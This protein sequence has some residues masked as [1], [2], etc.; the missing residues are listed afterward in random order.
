MLRTRARLKAP[1]LGI[2]GPWA[3][4]YPHLGI[5]GPAIG[6]LQETLRWLDHWLKGRPTGIMQE[7]MLRAW[8]PSGFT[9]AP[10]PDDRPG[11]WISEPGR[12]SGVR[13]E[14]HTSELQSH[15]NLVCRL[16]LE[17]KTKK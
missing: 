6:Y 12:S 11:R 2:F 7:P 8:L 1:R 13:S 4:R 14:E 15:L 5:P 17:K 16:L 3:H 9:V 10:T